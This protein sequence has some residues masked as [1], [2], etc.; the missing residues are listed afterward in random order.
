MPRAKKIPTTPAKEQF[1]QDLF[2]ISGTVWEA[3]VADWDPKPEP[4]AEFVIEVL[5]AGEFLTFRTGQG[6]KSV[7]LQIWTWERKRDYIWFH[8][9]EELDAYVSEMIAK[10]KAARAA[11]AAKKPL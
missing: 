2:D 1:E 3:T 5:M 6:G 9:T 10:M 7:G 11:R 8:E 4:L